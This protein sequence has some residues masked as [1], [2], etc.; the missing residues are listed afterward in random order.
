MLLK[1]VNCARPLVTL[2]ING[3][4]DD[5]SF[6]N[7]TLAR[8]I[9]NVAFGKMDGLVQNLVSL[10][11]SGLVLASSEHRAPVTKADMVKDGIVL[12]RRAR[13]VRSLYGGVNPQLND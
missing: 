7:C 2:V 13:S 1:I 6:D 3:T 10:V 8:S 9:G 4:C 5:D 12:P 11:L